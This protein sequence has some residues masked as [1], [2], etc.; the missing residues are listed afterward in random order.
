MAS[1][2]IAA[3]DK[4]SIKDEGG[5][6]ADRTGGGRRGGGYGYGG[7]GGGGSSGPTAEQKEAG[8]NL[9]GVA[10]FNAGTVLGTYDNTMD[11]YDVSDQQNK[12]LR[13][14]QIKQARRKSGT[15]WFRQ[16]KDLQTVTDNIL[17]AAGKALLGSFSYD[18]NDL[19]ADEDDAI[20]AETLET[21]RDNINSIDNS[22]FESLASLNNS[23]NDMAV[24][25]EQALRE[26]GADYV[27]QLNN[28]HPDLA[29]SYI[30]QENHTLKMPDWLDTDFYDE[31]RVEAAKP[32][33]YKWTR[34]DRANDTAYQQG[35]KTT[36]RATSQA[37]SGDYWSRLMSGYNNRYRQA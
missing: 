1:T 2:T 22:Y 33:D 15:D 35:V 11:M 31:H 9:G 37:A 32:D 18:L 14:T 34:P 25:T 17:D 6:N 28:I 26:L 4:V 27:A 36:D 5:G 30:D 23:R 10:G 8:A 12:N 24:N 7:S 13:D 19:I 20:D 29:D 16:Y 3:N 21:M